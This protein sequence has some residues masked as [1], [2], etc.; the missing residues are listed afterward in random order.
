MGISEERTRSLVSEAR[1]RIVALIDLIG[2]CVN[3]PHWAAPTVAPDLVS[4]LL[5]AS[6]C[7]SEGDQEAMRQLC[8][9]DA[10]NLARRISRWANEPDPPIR[11]V[12]GVWEWVSRRR[13]WPH[14][15][16]FINIHDLTTLQAVVTTVLG[17][18]DPRI[19]LA[20][21]QRWMASVH[22]CSPRYS[23]CLRE[24]LASGLALL[25]TEPNSIRCGTD[26]LSF[27]SYTVR[28]L[29][30][31]APDPRRWYSLA[32]VLPTLA[33]AAPEVLLDVIE[34]DVVGNQAVRDQLLEE[35]GAFGG[36]GR[37]CHLLWA[38]ERLAWSPLYLSRASIIMAALAEG[39]TNNG[40]G[41]RP[42]RSLR[43]IFLT[44][45]PNTRANVA[46]RLAA[47]DAMA[48][49]H[50]EIAF[51]LCLE[52]MPRRCDAGEIVV[53]PRW[54]DWATVNDHVVTN[55][56]RWDAVEG[57]FDRLLLWAANDPMRWVRLVDPI[58]EV[59]PERIETLINRLERLDFSAW[60]EEQMDRLRQSI[61]HQLHLVRTIEGIRP[62][63]ADQQMSRL[64][65]VYN[66][67]EPADL[68][69]RFGWLF[70]QNPD[71]LSVA[72]NNW[73]Y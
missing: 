42:D 67:L 62:D 26:V 47:I 17:E 39:W 44:W 61:R 30:G 59:G 70:N 50:Q 32:N 16:R 65:S 58:P 3:A 23:D 25:A 29:F 54:R 14:L 34:R 1:G 37:H 69:Q 11:L 41:N 46:Q 45:H 28:R 68:V 72:G 66:R 24:G 10:E 9:V 12:G 8:R 38:L 22:Q 13:A 71:L 48:Q 51:R 27:V 40:N 52:L 60:N 18:V 57:A 20:A 21:D 53:T 15:S 43:G 7:Q 35:E 63:L 31:D 2:G 5:A 33:E 49:K 73:L 64:E 6:W 36:G 4:F 19:E 55:G 56:E